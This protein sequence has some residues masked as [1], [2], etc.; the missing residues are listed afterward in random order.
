MYVSEGE[1]SET[2]IFMQ[3]HG[4]QYS[5]TFAEI[6]NEQVVCYYAFKALSW[7]ADK[8]CGSKLYCKAD[9]LWRL[10]H[11]VILDAMA[12]NYHQVPA[13]MIDAQ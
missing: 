12:E 7:A 3:L 5:I 10:I 2:K 8:I 6:E 1:N 4:E 9:S 13:Q 11:H